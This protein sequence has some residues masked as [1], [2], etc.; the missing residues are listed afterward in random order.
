MKMLF[1]QLGSFSIEIFLLLARVISE[2]LPATTCYL[3]VDY[4]RLRFVN[5]L[6]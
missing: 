6:L 2:L 4:V 5:A 3:S 1:V